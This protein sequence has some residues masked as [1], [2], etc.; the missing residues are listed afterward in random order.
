MKIIV[1][2][3]T[4]AFAGEALDVPRFQPAPESEVA[5]TTA[6]T[7]RVE[8]G[9]FTVTADGE[10]TGD[11][12]EVEAATERRL[13][14]VTVERYVRSVPERPL[15]LVRTFDEV[16]LELTS[17]LAVSTPNGEFEVAASGEGASELE[18]L[19]VRFEWNPENESYDATWSDEYDA[20]PELLE[21][22]RADAE[23][24]ALLPDPHGDAEVGDRWDVD[25]ERVNEV[26]IPGGA[27]PLDVTS[28]FD[29]IEGVLDPLR[30]PGPFDLLSDEFD[31]V[32]DGGIEAELTAMEDGVATIS[33]EVEIRL[34][35]DTLDRLQE[36][37]RE[38]VQ[39]DVGVNAESATY[40]MDLD[41]KGTL[42]WDMDAGRARSYDFE[43]KIETE[44][45]FE[46]VVDAGGES[47]DYAVR[48]TKEGEIELEVSVEKK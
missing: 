2:L 34:I 8:T 38:A 15:E 28:E 5:R 36:L 19:G 40:A 4:A 29:A 47:I 16:T 9:S 25:V 41:G 48:E 20:R 27:L 30:L 12:P 46:V 26:L 22:L 43:A 17:D 24:L 37:V 14:V 11:V 6:W 10:P 45:D 13:Q 1:P 7:S 42:V 44:V 18:G 35:A 32:I 3:V 23:F 21:P 31:P 39:P 33:F